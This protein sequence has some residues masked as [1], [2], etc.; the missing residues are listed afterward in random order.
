[1]AGVV[2]LSHHASSKDNSSSD[3]VLQQG[4]GINALISKDRGGG[5]LCIDSSGL[6]LGSKGII[7]TSR[8]GVYNTIAKLASQLNNG[9]DGGG[10]EM[11]LV[12]IETNM[13]CLLV[14]EYDGH[15]VVMRV[16]V[17]ESANN[18]EKDGGAADE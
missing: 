13:A 9:S 11:P 5:A 16:P 6:C 10:G 7:D 3:H 17:V 1:M 15:T 2:D 8:S 14:K 18:I 4:R 12:S